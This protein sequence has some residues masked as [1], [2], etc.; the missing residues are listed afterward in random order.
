MCMC[1]CACNCVKGDCCQGEGDVEAERLV[2]VIK[3]SDRSS[4]VDD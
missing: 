4:T 2:A 3:V 1:L